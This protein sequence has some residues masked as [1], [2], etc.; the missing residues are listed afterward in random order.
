MYKA[1]SF[2]VDTEVYVD[3]GDSDYIKYQAGTIVGTPVGQ[4][5]I[6]SSEET[7]SIQFKGNA[8]KEINITAGVTLNTFE[9]SCLNATN[10]EKFKFTGVNEINS[11]SNSWRGCSNLASWQ[12]SSVSHVTDFSRAWSECST[13]GALGRVNSREGLNFFESFKNSGITCIS[14]FDTT[15]QT[16]TTDMF[17]GTDMMKPDN[18]DRDFI[19]AGGRWINDID[20]EAGG[21]VCSKGINFPGIH[22]FEEPE[23][24][25]DS[26]LLYNDTNMSTYF[27]T[28]YIGIED[29]K[30]LYDASNILSSFLK[31]AQVYPAG[32]DEQ[33]LYDSSNIQ[34]SFNAK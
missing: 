23:L 2:I 14:L 15:K 34:G 12:M 33:L 3:W 31:T 28:G 11:V 19:R 27:L 24:D 16:N 21:I 7:K 17:F 29:E 30:L 25:D 26:V 6:R 20:C 5:R 22:F 18:L 10:L 8:A 1:I 4:V 9:N 13:L 32:Y